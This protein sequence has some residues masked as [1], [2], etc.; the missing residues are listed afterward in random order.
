M[1]EQESTRLQYEFRISDT[2]S[3][4]GSND[5]SVLIPIGPTVKT[6]LRPEAQERLQSYVATHW[7][8]WH[9]Y[10]YW[11]YLKGKGKGRWPRRISQTFEEHKRQGMTRLSHSARASL[12]KDRKLVVVQGY[13]KAA[14]FVAVAARCSGRLHVE[15]EVPPLNWFPHDQWG[16]RTNL[17]TSVWQSGETHPEC[18][19]HP[20]GASRQR[21]RERF[22]RYV[23]RSSHGF[24]TVP[25]TFAGYV[26]FG[27]KPYGRAEMTTCY[28]DSLVVRTMNSRLNEHGRGLEVADTLFYHTITM[29]P[30]LPL[31]GNL[32]MWFQEL[33][34]LSQASLYERA[35]K[36]WSRRVQ[37]LR[38]TDGRREDEDARGETDWLMKRVY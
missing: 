31:L 30:D 9:N 5:S 17:Q 23:W 32:G 7:D 20:A 10:P 36:L 15:F 11:A 38:G 29:G 28:G 27:A 4:F 19:R 8:D 2:K 35:M 12:F 37:L 22:R 33:P 25:G 1:S 21:D 18:D 6:T 24:R 26:T 16:V 14:C 13:V 3:F 34:N